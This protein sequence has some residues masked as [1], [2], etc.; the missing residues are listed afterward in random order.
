MRETHLSNKGVECL[1]AI[2][3]IQC[4]R[5][6]CNHITDERVE[7][8]GENCVNLK[9]LN[10]SEN[11]ITSLKPL[12]KLKKLTSLTACLTDVTECDN[13]WLKN[14][15]ILFINLNMTFIEGSRLREISKI[16]ESKSDKKSQYQSISIYC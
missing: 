7:I 9:D 13:S 3:H 16:L 14:S 5:L 8:I 1:A 6:T 11:L 4:L 12:Y 2:P 15:D 10:I